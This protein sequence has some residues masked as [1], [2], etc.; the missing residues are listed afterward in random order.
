MKVFAVGACHHA[1]VATTCTIISL[2]YAESANLFGK[3]CITYVIW[4]LKIASEAIC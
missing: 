4:G 1:Y 3:N 2:S